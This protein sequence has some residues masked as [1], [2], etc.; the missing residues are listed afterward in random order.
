MLVDAIVTSF[1]Q[2]EDEEDAEEE[3]YIP[4]RNSRPGVCV[5]RCI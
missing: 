3:A 5:Q 1:A 4:R 2:M